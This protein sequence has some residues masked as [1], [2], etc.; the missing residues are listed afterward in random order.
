M[1]LPKRDL[2]VLLRTESMSESA[3]EA[4]VEQLGEVLRS[5][6]NADA[7]CAANELVKRN[8]ITRKRLHILSAA[9]YATMQPFYFL[10]NKN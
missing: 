4:H 5:V 2:L 7:F 10:L 6:E 3:I 1:K 9:R 8:R